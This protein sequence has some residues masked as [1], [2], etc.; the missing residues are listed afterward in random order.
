MSAA[1]WLV[2]T[3]TQYIISPAPFTPQGAPKRRPTCSCRLISSFTDTAC[4]GSQILRAKERVRGSHPAIDVADAPKDDDEQR[5]WRQQ[6]RITQVAHMHREERGGGEEEARA[7][8]LLQGQGLRIQVNQRLANAR[9]SLALE[10]LNVALWS[11]QCRRSQC[12]QARTPPRPG[13]KPTV[14]LSPACCQLLTMHMFA[15]LHFPLPAHLD[16][17]V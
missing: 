7:G 17:D 4:E 8:P 11:S 1:C 3:L 16:S 14:G 15:L 2:R 9:P 6:P 10:S 12:M 13:N 5:V